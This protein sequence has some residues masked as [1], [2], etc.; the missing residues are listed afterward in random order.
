MLVRYEHFQYRINEFLR[1][2]VIWTGYRKQ[3]RKLVD[4]PSLPFFSDWTASMHADAVAYVRRYRSPP[5][6]VLWHRAFH[7]AT[8]LHDQRY[9]SDPLFFSRIEPRLSQRTRIGK[10][11]D[12]NFYGRLQITSEPLV[13]ARVIA[14]RLTAADLSGIDVE[15]LQAIVASHREIVVKPALDSGG[16]NGIHFVKPDNLVSLLAQL[17]RQGIY[18]LVVQQPIQQCAALASLNPDSVNTLRILTMRFGKR[19]INLSTV[20]RIGRAG[21]RIDNLAAGGLCVG[22]TGQGRLKHHAYDHHFIRY[23]RHPDSNV[24]FVDYPVPAF[25]A[26]VDLCFE[27]HAVIPDVDLISWD[28][29]VTS[30]KVPVVVELNMNLQ[31]IALHQLCNG[32]LFGDL[33]ELM[34]ERYCR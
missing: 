22:M 21:C 8:G 3:L 14:G 27:K 11:F 12:K 33:T 15:R 18:D 34:Y 17:K 19:I 28:V 9:V 30:E 1:N 4:M 31:G 20:L 25:Q 13:L 23:E 6:S 7:A 10:Y 24:L 2:R 29:A 26:A 5:V 32:P 16:G